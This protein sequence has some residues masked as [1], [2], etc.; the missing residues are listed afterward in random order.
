MLVVIKGVAEVDP[1]LQ[2]V[3]DL[4]RTPDLGGGR[5][6]RRV[7]GRDQSGCISP[8]NG[9]V[10]GI[11]VAVLHGD[12]GEPG[13]AERQTEVSGHRQGVAVTFVE[14]AL[15]D[16]DAAAGTVVLQHEIQHAGDGVRAILC[17]SPVAEHLDLPQRDARDGPDVGPLGAV[18]EAS[19]EPGDDRA[20]VPALAV[21]QDQG[22]VR[23]QAAQV[24]RTRDRRG[25]ADRLRV[26]V[27]RRHHGPQQEVDVGL[28]LTG[29]L[30]NRDHVHGDHRLGDGAGPGAASHH[31]Q[32][33]ERERSHPECD[34]DVEGLARRNRHLLG[35][36][37]EAEE[38]DF[39]RVCARGHA[40]NREAAGCSGMVHQPQCGNLDPGAAESQSALDVA[41]GS[42]DRAL[43]ESG[44]GN[45]QQG[46]GHECSSDHVLLLG[47]RG[48]VAPAL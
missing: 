5:T 11:L 46:E 18:G 30:R 33:V 31:H 29:D 2:V 32:F 22:V 41:D 44:R 43:G 48:G 16:L 8:L 45:G 23:C 14:A 38:T 12:V 13:L 17:R 42:F 6:D 24:G 3:R 9:A 28:C 25:V 27:V 4:G 21:E 47:C 26:D 39:Q 36:K 10:G 19:A 35:V 34:V 37:A 15:L 40:G 1:R 20:P 7:V